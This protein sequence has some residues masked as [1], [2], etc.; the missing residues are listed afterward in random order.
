VPVTPQVIGGDAA[1]TV[2]AAPEGSKA[3]H[4]ET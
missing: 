3:R 2:F 4:V 1:G